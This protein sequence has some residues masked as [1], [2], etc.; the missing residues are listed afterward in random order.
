MRAARILG[1]GCW[2]ASMLL[3]S[4]VVTPFQRFGGTAL[5]VGS[6]APWSLA[7]AA[8]VALVVA[9]TSLRGLFLPR[10]VLAA[11][12]GALYVVG[13]AAF[14]ALA[15]QGEAWVSG[16]ASWGGAMPAC[17]TAALSACTGVGCVG[18]GLAWG[19]AFKA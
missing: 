11:G 1:L 9:L 3:Y 2:L 19:R 8:G 7:C 12:G 16:H 10:R 17:V 4:N 15:C 6:F 5:F 14:A 18:T 13:A